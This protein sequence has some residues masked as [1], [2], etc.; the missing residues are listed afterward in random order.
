MRPPHHLAPM[1]PHRRLAI[2][3]AAA[4]V[5]VVV[6]AD[7][8]LLRLGAI[9]ALLLAATSYAVWSAGRGDWTRHDRPAAAPDPQRAELA[10]ARVGEP[11]HALA[12][13]ILHTQHAPDE[14]WHGEEHLWMAV[15]DAWLWLLHQTRDGEI[16]G[17]K[18]RFSRAGMHSRWTDHRVCS[19]HVGE[20]SWPAEPWF[21]AGELHGARAQRIRLIGLLAGDELGVRDLVTRSDNPSST[22]SDIDHETGGK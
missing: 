13:F 1:I 4:L 20:L 8:L 10:S 22:G 14:R 12:S 16:G 6:F 7:A 5:T 19:H 9:A 21:I 18:S 11:T 15:T 2:A 3:V 17:V